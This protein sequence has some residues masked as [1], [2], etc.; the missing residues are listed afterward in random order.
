MVDD[1]SSSGSASSETMDSAPSPAPVGS[2]IA[3]SR[4]AEKLCPAPRT[5]TTRTSSG[6]SRP[7]A[8]SARHMVGVCALR[9][10]GRSSVI[11]ATAPST[12]Y[13]SPAA[14]SSSGVMGEV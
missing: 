10:S 14:V 9:T 12:E 11:V 5:S 7:T 4:P 13:W 3:R 8:A 1:S 2:S 6:I